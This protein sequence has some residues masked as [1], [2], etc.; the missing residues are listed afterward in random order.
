MS[1]TLIEKIWN[2]HLIGTRADG[3]DLVYMDRLVLHELHAPHAFNRLQQ[4]GRGV[5][6]PDL[7]FAALDHT[8]ATLPGRDDTTNPQGTEF[9]R[10]TRDESRRLGIPGI[11]SWPG[12]PGDLPCGGAGAGH[13]A[14]RG[15]HA[16]P[17]SHAC[18]VGGIGALGFGCGTTELE[19][20]LA[21]QLMA[22]KRPKQM[23]IRLLGRLASWV[24]AKDVILHVISRLGVGRRPGLHG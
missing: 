14:A 12:S 18:T 13:G 4:T 6:R 21:T 3:R 20:V 11:R 17:D 10:T 9:I 23:R 1:L 22:I 16:V 5:R 7:A 2:N 15:D 19:H 24:G 8:V